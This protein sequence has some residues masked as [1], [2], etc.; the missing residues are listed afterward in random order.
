MTEKNGT[1]RSG[2]A[3]I[4]VWLQSLEKTIEPNVNALLARGRGVYKVLRREWQSTALNSGMKKITSDGRK[5][6]DELKDRAEAASSEAL[7]SVVRLQSTV[8]GALGF[9]TRQQI[10]DLTR[11]VKRLTKK[12]GRSRAPRP[13][14]VEAEAQQEHR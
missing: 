12:A 5:R 11:T 3:A 14:S 7:E 13:T 2:L 4:Q 9:A 6:L 1:G 10:D 8:V